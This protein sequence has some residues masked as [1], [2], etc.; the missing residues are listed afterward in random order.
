MSVT[1][2]S[3]V[4]CLDSPGLKPALPP[5]VSTITKPQ[6]TI[7]LPKNKSHTIHLQAK[8]A[9]LTDILTELSNKTGVKIHYSQLPAKP[10]TSQCDAKDVKAV[11][12]CLL[13]TGVDLA[14]KSPS[15]AAI[16]NRKNRQDAEVW[17]LSTPNNENLLKTLAESPGL[18]GAPKKPA[19]VWKRTAETEKNQ[20]DAM[21]NDAVS[22][23]PE[24]RATA[25]YNL[26]LTGPKDNVEVNE[27]LRSALDDKNANVRSQAAISLSQRGVAA[28]SPDQQL[29]GQTS[30]NST[31]EDLALLKKISKSSGKQAVELIKEMLPPGAHIEE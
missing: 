17:L 29:L 1:F 25:I 5:P 28:D 13:G 27:V 19:R 15:N 3:Q 7:T 14:V 10:I 18:V 6:I 30:D 9:P 4:F 11:M 31:S 2:S 12:Q 16:V 22:D 21:L 20:L 26:G 8:Q 23:N 24:L